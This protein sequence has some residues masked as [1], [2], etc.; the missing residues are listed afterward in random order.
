MQAH[1]HTHKN[2][3]ISQ[4]PTLWTRQQQKVEW[5]V[6]KQK[7]E[8]EDWPCDAPVCG[9]DEDGGHVRLQGSVQEREALNVQHVNFVDEQ[10]LQQP[11]ISVNITISWLNILPQFPSLIG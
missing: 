6:D 5:A 3:H 11:Q 2:I 9:H 4:H 7:V 10:H 1:T 8:E